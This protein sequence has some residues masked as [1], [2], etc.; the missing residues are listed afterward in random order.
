MQLCFDPEHFIDLSFL[1]FL[2]NYWVDC[3]VILPL[4]ILLSLW[5]Y[6]SSSGPFECVVSE[7]IESLIL[8]TLVD[9]LRKAMQC[10]IKRLSYF[11][12]FS[13]RVNF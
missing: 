12:G 7:R 2:D 11:F 1:R 10:S 4:V 6:D 9:C 8:Q 3:N 13:S 5:L